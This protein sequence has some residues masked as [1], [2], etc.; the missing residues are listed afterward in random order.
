MHPNSKEAA[1]RTSSENDLQRELKRYTERIQRSLLAA[2]EQFKD[3]QFGFYYYSPGT[4]AR[5]MRDLIVEHARMA[6]SGDKKVRIIDRRG[7]IVFL[8]S[9]S[10][11]NIALR[12]KKF[13]KYLRCSNA[14][15][16]QATRFA[17]QYQLFADVLPSVVHLNAGYRTNETWT[18]IECFIAC[19]DGLRSNAWTINLPNTIKTEPIVEN[20]SA[21]AP[22]ARVRVKST[23]TLKEVNE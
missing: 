17:S 6:F 9:G 1:M 19:P 8:L 5:I 7:M 15:T 21:V 23:T 12:F 14:R 11:A 22:A 4:R 13:D 2:W 10:A 20:G 16:L 18:E 3:E